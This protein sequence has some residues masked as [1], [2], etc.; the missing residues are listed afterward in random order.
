M[1]KR[2]SRNR[3][4]SEAAPGVAIA[5]ART[6]PPRIDLWLG[7]ALAA[8][9][10]AVYARVMGFDFVTLDD[11]VYVTENP[12]VQAGLS[13]AGVVWAWN[14]SFGGQWHPLTWLS[15]MLDCQLFGL[16]AGWHHFTNVL[17]H[18]LSTVVCFRLFH[19]LT[20]AR[21][22]SLVVA[23]VF[24][25]HPLHVESVAWVCE[26]KDVLSALFWLLTLLAY[27]DYAARPGRRRYLL[28]LLIF[29][30]GL[31]SKPMV[32]T[33]PLV[34]V[35]MDLWPLRRGIRILEKLPFFAASL[36]VSVVTVLVHEKVGALPSLD[37]V[38][39]G[40]RIENALL[41]YVIY[42]GQMFWPANLAVFYPYAAGSL[43]IPAVLAGILLTAITV[44]VLAF[45]RRPYLAFGWFWYLVTLLPVSGLIQAGA[46]SRADRF[47]YIPMIGISVAVVW[48]VAE[49]WPEWQRT[50]IAV[51]TAVCTACAVLTFVQLSYWRDSVALYEHAIDVTADNYVVR[52]NLASVLEAN[53]NRADAVAQL[54]EA[55]RIRPKSAAAHAELGQLLAQQRQP[56]EAL[57]ELDTAISLRPE[58]ADT[59]LRLGSVLGSLGRNQEAAA[60][61]VQAVRLDPDNADAHYNF[62]IAL[63]QTGRLPEAAQEFGACVRLNPEDADARFNFG[64]TLAKMGRFDEAIAQLSQ[65]VHIRR[66]FGEARQALADLMAMKQPARTP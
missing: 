51:A 56:E 34:L 11:P 44:T 48:A 43:L 21:W 19:R 49:A 41:S 57:R 38:P 26:R 27:T 45:R 5:R 12:H 61:F 40:V 53:G 59:H 37:L 2:R 4:V 13:W 25:F 23:L 24:A 9:V 63:A 10:I 47:T 29:C 28:A 15:H 39:L 22:N 36:A 33:L 66:D 58:N 8:A 17:I 32:V 16:N 52:F 3:P 20:G 18:A 7:L 1:S 31:M 46:Q 55:A 62:G 6:S 50:R 60:E 64:I 42:L 65:A 35:L 14:A 54:R 30:L